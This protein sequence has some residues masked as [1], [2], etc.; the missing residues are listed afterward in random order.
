MTLLRLDTV[1]KK[2]LWGTAVP[3]TVLALASAGW[4]WGETLV[5]VRDVLRVA[6]VFSCGLLAAT[7]VS[8][9]LFLRRPLRRLN[10]AMLRAEEGDLLVRAHVSGVDELAQLGASFNRM[11]ARLTAMKAEEIDTRR[12][13]AAARGMLAFKD[14]LQDRLVELAL[15]FDV[16]RSLNATLEL[17][18]LLSRITGLVSE[19]LRISTFSIMLTGGAGELEVKD[20]YPSKAEVEGVCFS[21]G[22]GAC[23]RAAQAHRALY[24]PDLREEDSGFARAGLIAEEGGALLCVP[25]V[26]AS[27]LLGVLNFHR[28]DPGTFSSSEID[29]LTAVADQAAM[30]VKNARLHEETVALTITDPLTGVPNRRHLFARLEMELARASRFGT[31]VSILMIDIDHFK[32]LNDAAGHRAGDDTLRRVCSLLRGAVRQVDTLARYGG[33]EFMLLLPQVTKAEAREVGEKLR[34]AVE[35]HVFPNGASQPSGKVTVSIGVANWPVDATEQDRLVD[36]AD[37]ALYAS[38]REG[39]NLVTAYAT[40]MEL[41]P[42]RARGPRTTSRSELPA[43]LPSPRA[44]SRPELPAAVASSGGAGRPPQGS[45]GSTT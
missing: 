13:L 21:V 1:G 39:R 2:L 30:A 22:Q 15:L 38:K 28:R 5:P 3:G 23:G 9:H 32:L 14:E 18:E 10:A 17:P 43:A 45:S 27:E 31:Q 33:E 44:V 35:T 11:L 37:A 12:D 34:R 24:L 36:C 6:L 29:L 25:L 8:L 4:L 16:A 19:R 40:G 7:T 26:H 42:G 41:H 20:A